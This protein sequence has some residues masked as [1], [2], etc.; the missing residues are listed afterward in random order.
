MQKTAPA[1]AAAYKELG[2]HTIPIAVAKGK[3]SEEQAAELA[4]ILK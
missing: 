1:I 2:R 3:I 4:E